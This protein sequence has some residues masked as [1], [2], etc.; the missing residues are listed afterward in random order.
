[1]TRLE[2]SEFNRSERDAHEL[3]HRM[4][5]RFQHPADLAILSLDEFDHEMCFPRG[6]LPHDHR[7]RPKAVD[8]F[9]HPRRVLVVECAS[10]GHDVSSHDR[11][12]RISQVVRQLTVG[13]QQQEPRTRHVEPSDGDERFRCLAEHIEY[14]GPALR[15]APSGENTFRLVEGNCAPLSHRGL[16]AVNGDRAVLGD[17]EV[18]RIADDA[19]GDSDS[20]VRDQSLRF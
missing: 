15:V 10:H 11:V 20:A 5:E 9:G 3:C 14:G 19:P 4:A 2:C 16:C 7:V 17:D 6:S 8:A 12:R 1:L 18:C 13:R